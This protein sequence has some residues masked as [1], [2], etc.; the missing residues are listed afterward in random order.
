MELI[1]KHMAAGKGQEQKSFWFSARGQEARNCIEQV[2]QNINFQTEQNVKDERRGR[3]MKQLGICLD[4]AQRSGARYFWLLGLVWFFCGVQTMLHP[5][6][7]HEPTAAPPRARELGSAS[8]GSRHSPTSV[9][10][11]ELLGF[12]W[13]FGFFLGITT[14]TPLADRYGRRRIFLL[15][16]FCAQCAVGGI[17]FCYERLA[18]KRLRHSHW[19]PSLETVVFL[20]YLCRACSGAFIGGGGT[21][22]HLLMLE[23]CE[24]NLRHRYALSLHVWFAL[25]GGA[26]AG[27]GW[28]YLEGDTAAQLHLDVDEIASGGA[29]PEVVETAAPPASGGTNGPG[30][31]SAAAA[32]ARAAAYDLEHSRAKFLTVLAALSLPVYAMC[33][34][35]VRESAI[36]EASRARGRGEAPPTAAENGRCGA[37][38]GGR[39]RSSPAAARAGGPRAV[40]GNK[41]A[42]ANKFILLN[43]AEVEVDEEAV[44][45]EEIGRPSLASTVASD[46]PSVASDRPPVASDGAPA[47][48]PRG[49]RRNKKFHLPHL[50]TL[51]YQWLSVCLVYYGISFSVERLTSDIYTLAALLALIEIPAC[52]LADRTMRSRFFGRQYSL[53]AF[54]GLSAASCLLLALNFFPAP[55]EYH[56]LV[57]GK[58]FATAAFAL[59]YTYG[60]E[61]FPTELRGQALALQSASSRVAG[62]G[63]P[64]VLSA[65]K[66][67]GTLFGLFCGLGVCA[68]LAAWKWL[69]ETREW[70]L[71]EA[72]EGG[73]GEGEEMD[74]EA[75]VVERREEAA[76][77]EGGTSEKEDDNREPVPG[78][79]KMDRLVDTTFDKMLN[80]TGGLATKVDADQLDAS[81]IISSASAAAQ[82]SPVCRAQERYSARHR[83]CQYFNEPPS[84]ATTLALSLFAGTGVQGF[85]GDCV[86]YPDYLE[87]CPPSLYQ[88]D[89][90]SS[91]TTSY[92]SDVAMD[93]FGN[94]FVADVGNNRVRLITK[95]P[96]PNVAEAVALILNDGAVYTGP[97][98]NTLTGS[99]ARIS[100][101]MSSSSSVLENTASSLH[102]ATEDKWVAATVVNLAGAFGFAGDG[103][104]SKLAA[105]RSP[106]AI[107]VDME[108]EAGDQR[109]L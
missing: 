57:S 9:V 4:I 46:R 16:V 11:K 95:V 37:A 59:L 43:A 53:I 75:R 84:P 38:G 107:A 106:E 86:T 63:L 5:F 97:A 22:A 1:L 45:M 101:G 104:P 44:E 42:R 91:F 3:C 49:P 6:L 35:H 31:R 8:G 40:A 20:I 26:V 92:P 71:E 68:C 14:L 85:A 66:G 96:A 62:L 87:S 29:R 56:L 109:W 34:R 60:S 13:F 88:T 33:F 41:T 98:G 89:D 79:Q 77:D 2:C 36:W 48:L 99:G 18:A 21:V 105:L 93:G 51:C 17:A 83:R 102:L 76:R 30:S 24:T 80:A 12:S 52:F 81:M 67:R 61:V 7:V 15:A 108:G 78:E 32:E 69:P 103:G 65:L 55:F 58:L 73:D 100:V 10:S 28:L 50:C 70:A 54:F 39:Q 82:A 19:R 23:A 74:E 27:L 72:G 47:H 25:G 64:F 90:S 94:L